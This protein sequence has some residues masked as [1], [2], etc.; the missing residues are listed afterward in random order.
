MKVL[1]LL[2]G[3]LFYTLHGHQVSRCYRGYC[4]YSLLA[5]RTFLVLFFRAGTCDYCC[6]LTQR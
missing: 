2:E 5:E 6:I 3:R 1:D 4:Q